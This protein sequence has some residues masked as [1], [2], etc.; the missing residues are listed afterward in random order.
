MIYIDFI[1]MLYFWYKDKAFEDILYT[2]QYFKFKKSV[3]KNIKF[4][5]EYELDL[6]KCVAIDYLVSWIL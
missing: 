3:D 1:A 6:D 5:S 4:F 2:K